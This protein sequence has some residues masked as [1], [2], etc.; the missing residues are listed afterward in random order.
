MRNV[1]H[2][3]RNVMDEALK[4]TSMIIAG[5][6]SFGA[7]SFWVETPPNIDTEV[8]AETLKAQGVLIEAGAPFFESADGPKNFFRLA[9]SSIPSEKI[10]EGVRRIEQAIVEMQ[11]GYNST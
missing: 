4:G 3:R 2:K 7:S 11:T 8:L 6:A 5:S 1:F 10:P 9:Y